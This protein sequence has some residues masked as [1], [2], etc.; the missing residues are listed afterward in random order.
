[1]FAVYETHSVGQSMEACKSG[2]SA[3]GMK[4]WWRNEERKEGEL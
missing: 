2:Q 3:E 4:T 1:M